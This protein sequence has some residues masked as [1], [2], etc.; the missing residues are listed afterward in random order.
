M[1]ALLLF[2]WT[3]WTRLRALAG[4]VGFHVLFA[5][6]VDRRYRHPLRGNGRH[7]LFRQRPAQV[8]LPADLDFDIRTG[9]D[10]S[11]HV[12]QPALSIPVCSGTPLVARN[13]R[14]SVSVP[15]CN[16]SVPHGQAIIDSQ[17]FVDAEDNRPRRLDPHGK[18]V[19]F[20]CNL[21]RMRQSVSLFF[22][23]LP[24]P[25]NRTT[26]AQSRVYPNPESTWYEEAA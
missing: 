26:L 9:A 15:P 4:A 21:G 13:M 22:R 20:V 2:G 24:A 1:T 5:K 23:H 18:G 7:L 16:R 6:T 25:S 17:S 11:E 14:G 10:P 8:Q 19:E 12:L 3:L